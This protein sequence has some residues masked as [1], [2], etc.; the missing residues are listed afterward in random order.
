MSYNSHTMS[1]S[2]IFPTHHQSCSSL[3]NAVS[4]VL[5]LRAQFTFHAHYTVYLS[6]FLATGHC[7]I[8]LEYN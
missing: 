1:N 7:W 6:M 5:L 4:N 2:A 8:G 3:R